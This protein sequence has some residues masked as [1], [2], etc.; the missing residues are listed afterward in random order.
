MEHSVF[1]KG[2]SG[3]HLTYVSKYHNDTPKGLSSELYM[4]LVMSQKAQFPNTKAVTNY[5]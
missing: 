2:K 4:S 1:V 5:M 3:K